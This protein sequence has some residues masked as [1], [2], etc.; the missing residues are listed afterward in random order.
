MRLVLQ[1]LDRFA[2][3]L[4]STLGANLLDIVVHGSFVLGDFRPNQGDLDYMVVT[5]ID[6][7]DSVNARLF[8]LHDDY[9]R[10][11]QLLLHQLEG[12][13]Y[14][15]GFLSH[16]A[17]SFVGCYIGTSRGGWRTITTLQNSYMDLRIIGECGVHL[18][19]Y[20]FVLYRPSEADIRRE[21]ELDLERFQT[22]TVEAAA[23]DAG[24]WISLIHWCA[25]TI[26]YVESNH[27]TSK[28]ES[29]RWCARAP[30]FSEFGELFSFAENR[31]YPYVEQVLDKSMI[32]MCTCL[33]RKV[34]DLLHDAKSR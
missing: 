31:R 30:H 27:P 24:R 9:Q 7:D 14:P 25:R 22:G 6:L 26:Y 21:Q 15:K 34:G 33:L 11:K 4:R 13:Y 1:T 17:P 23:W 12:T 29:C 19:G 20:D 10:G 28:G 2:D 18:L 32:E 3:D 8:D 5:D 16:L